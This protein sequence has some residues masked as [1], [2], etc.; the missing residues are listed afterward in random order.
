MTKFLVGVIAFGL[1]P[2]VAGLVAHF[3]DVYAF[4]T[5]KSAKDMHTWKVRQASVHPHSLNILFQGYPVAL[6]WYAF[7]VVALQVHCFEIYFA[8]TLIKAWS[9]RRK[10]Q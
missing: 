1:L 10:T 3:P 2:V 9:P 4:V 5:T 6:L 7:F 8:K